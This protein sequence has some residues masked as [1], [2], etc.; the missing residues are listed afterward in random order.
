MPSRDGAGS[1]RQLLALFL[2]TTLVLLTALGWLGWQSLQQDRS[3]E[4]QQVNE[5]VNT[6]ADLIAA[7]IRQN[8]IDIEAELG[9]LSLL[10]PDGLKRA[11][12]DYSNALGGDALVVV[13]EGQ[14]VFAYPAG[15]LLYYPTLPDPVEAPPDRFS[16]GETLEL[17][18][19]DYRGAAAHFA[20]L[21]ESG[22]HEIRAGALIRLARTQRKAGDNE[23]ALATYGQLA[24]ITDAYLFGWPSDLRARKTRC[25]LLD[26]LG[27]R[28][29]LLPEAH[30]L[31]ADL[32]AGKWMLTRATFMYLT[33]EVRRWLGDANPTDHHGAALALAAN[34][35]SL[36]ERWQRDPAGLLGTQGNVV[37][38]DQSTALSRGTPNRVVAI[39]SGALFL[40]HHVV[41]PLRELLDRY[42][43]GLTL[44]DGEGRTL[45][46]HNTT[47]AGEARPVMR[48]MEETR[49]P[50]TLLVVS[51]D[52]AADLARLAA[53]RSLL[54]GA[55]VLLALLAVAG[56]YFSV[57][58]MTREIKAARLQSEFVAAVSH[59]FRTPLTS[60]RQFT[61]LLADGRV[62]DE[63]D[64]QKYYEVLQRG[65]RRLTRLVENLLDFGRMEAGFYQFMLEPMRAADVFARVTAEFVD[66]MKPRGYDVD[67]QW[68]G[69]HDVLIDADEATLGRAIWNLM[70]NAVKY[71][72]GCRTIWVRGSSSDAAV[73]ISIRDQGIGIAGPE[74]RTIFGKFVRGTL[75]V[76]T[77]IKGTGLGLA[78]V[79][80]IVRAHGGHVRVE[81]AIGEG[82]TFLIILPIQRSRPAASHQPTTAE[83][84]S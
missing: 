13:F 74:Q 36:W 66:E 73:T 32:H 70:D 78:L 65:T 2:G 5:R 84:R 49:L 51:A 42:G 12:E 4:A 20:R 61:D 57:R 62:S 17:R 19:R 67:V 30:Q 79:D 72:P 34:V 63:A 8:L 27:R 54:I 40:D 21:A 48:T 18:D 83:A 31:N 26:Q 35:D 53:R 43:V 7:Q 59:E 76:G 10:P 33:S 15:R 9:R 11:A 24:K 55:L 81:S 14:R 39:V 75:P 46:A 77:T 28:A 58:A 23:A 29:E 60:L 44:A 16:L 69:P 45:F 80:Q 37:S 3:I 1:P 41:A 56:S 68:T 64:R 71:S 22:D 82:S 50:W 6:A 38:R 52:P 25:D 47:T